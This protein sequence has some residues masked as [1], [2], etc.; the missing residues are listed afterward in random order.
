MGSDNSL[1]GAASRWQAIIC[2]NGDPVYKFVYA[3]LGL[4]ALTLYKLIPNCFEEIW[5][6]GWFL[7]FLYTGMTQVAEIHVHECQVG[8]WF[9]FWTADIEGSM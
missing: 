5:E 3:S 4:D 9:T 6:Y 2:N 7:P 1:A 8:D